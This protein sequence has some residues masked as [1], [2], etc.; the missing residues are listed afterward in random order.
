MS[1]GFMVAS[2]AMALSASVRVN[3]WAINIDSQ[4][5]DDPYKPRPRSKGE[6]ARNKRYR[7]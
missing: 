1:K 5:F 7:K 4:G 2:I 6:K 3:G